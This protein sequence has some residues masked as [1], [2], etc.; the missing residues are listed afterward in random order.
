MTPIYIDFE[1]FWSTEHT[2][3][4]M[5]PTEYVMHPDTEII[6]VAI[7]VGNEPTYVLFGEQKIREYLQS[8][9]W[10]DAMAIGHNM[11]GFDAMILA[12]RMGVNP[13]MYGCTAAM[14][15][16]KY[17]KTSAFVNGKSLTGVS[18]KKLAVELKVGAKLDLEATNTKGKHLCDFSEDELAQMEDYN[19]V[20]TDLCAAIFKKLAPSFPKQELLQIDMTTRMLVEPKF[21]LNYSMV[22]KALEDVKAE[23]AKALNDLYDLLFTQAESVARKLEGD[24]TSP[25]EYVRMTMA[26]SAKFGELLRSRGVEVPMKVSPTNPQKMVPA[27]AKTDDGFIKLQEHEDPIIAAA[28]RVRLEVKSTLLETRLQAFLRAADACDGRLPVPLKYCG[29]DTTGRWS[30][31]QYN[32]QNLPRIDTKNPKPSDALRMSLKAPKG[33]K[34]IVADLSGIELRVNMFLWKV[35]YAMELF[36]SSPDKADLYRYFAAH[37]LYNIT[38]D[39]VTKNQRQVGKVAHLGLGFG[40]G[41]ATFQKVAKLMGGIDLSLEEATDVVNKYREAHGEIVNG[42]K[43][44]QSNLT[45]IRQGI[46]SSIDPWGMCQVEHEAVRLPSGRRIYYPSLVKQVD[47]GKHEWWYGNNR[48]KAR[49]YAGKG[50]ENLVQALARDVIAEHAVRFYKDTSLRPSLAVHDELVYVVPEKAAQQHLDH[51]QG[52]MR[53][54]VSWWP[55]LVTWSE[56]DIADCYGE[57]K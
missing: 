21:L 31:E 19:K 54:G 48:S 4:R 16:P 6:S 12:W 27:L 39:E 7:K 20:D 13:K 37:D 57:A 1:S 36:A 33:H 10:S 24:P 42:W 14:A 28:A 34:I 30:G 26:S 53:Q 55:E 44:F 3:T 5:S 43:Q 40:A 47:N 38:E 41:G 2:L 50:V 9:D 45:N 49:I 15:R 22:D 25:E 32:M 56:G 23:K 35:P 11:S 8:L 46:E 18:L 17:S 52:I 29:A 51:L